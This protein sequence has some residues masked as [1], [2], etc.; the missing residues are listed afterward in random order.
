MGKRGQERKRR[1]KQ[2]EQ[3]AAAPT[4]PKQSNGTA[5][6][7]SDIDPL[8]LHI[9][10]DVLTRITQSSELEEPLWKR[11]D[12]KALRTKVFTLYTAMTDDRAAGRSLGGRISDALQ[13]KDYL[14]ARH[15]LEEMKQKQIVPKLGS[16]QRWVRECDAAFSVNGTKAA[17]TEQNDVL[18][19]LDAMIRCTQADVVREANKDS[20]PTD[21]IIKHPDWCPPSKFGTA[22]DETAAD[23]YGAQ[24][25][26]A[27]ASKFRIVSTEK[28]LHRKPPNKHDAVVYTSCPTAVPLAPL[29]P[30]TIAQHPVPHV[31]G[32]FVLTDVLTPHECTRIIQAAEAIKFMPDEP[33]D[34]IVA[35][36]IL[37]HNV[38]WLA[39]PALNKALYDRCAAFLPNSLGLNARWRVYRY[40]PGAVYRPHIDGSWPGSGLHP[41]T[42][43]Y[44]YDA[45]GD[46]QSKMTFLLRLNDDFEGGATTYFVPSPDVGFMHARGVTTPRGSVV[47]FPH[48]DAQGSL[49]HEGSA[50]TRGYKYIVRTDVLYPLS[51]DHGRGKIT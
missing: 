5:E 16:L 27:L 39:D 48:G 2:S 46:R 28:G 45:Y 25:A 23:G 29:P 44:M 8:D 36:S 51:T 43:E 14:L 35:R 31:P 20:A 47:C 26:E 30:N 38:Y 22:G 21:L 1:R 12:F 17:D 11:K 41:Q 42:G 32:C 49:L 9:T 24:D 40:E 18:R 50:V 15:L 3:T 6:D 19:V 13:S 37:A 4:F 10:L 33:L 7:D 34:D